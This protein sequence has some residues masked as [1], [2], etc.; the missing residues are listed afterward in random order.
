MRRFQGEFRNNAGCVTERVPEGR[1][2]AL[3]AVRCALIPQS[4]SNDRCSRS[5]QRQPAVRHTPNP[6]GM[7]HAAL[8]PLD[9]L[10]A[11]RSEAEGR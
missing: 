7:T 5:P 9:T 10:G 8:T 3:G 2:E 11:T 4:G 1:R 6:W